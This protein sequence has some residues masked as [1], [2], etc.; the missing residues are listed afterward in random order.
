MTE[1][2]VVITGHYNR[3][4]QEHQV[5]PLKLPTDGLAALRFDTL[6]D[7]APTGWW[8]EVQ[9][10]AEPVS[11]IPLHRTEIHH[12]AYANLSGT[13]MLKYKAAICFVSQAKSF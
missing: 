3:H 12:P 4:V 7:T 10:T 6:F 13:G 9:G 5:I 11:E 1:R 8:E 2:F